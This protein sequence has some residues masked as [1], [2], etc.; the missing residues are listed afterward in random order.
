MLFFYTN[1]LEK[2]EKVIN[3]EMYKLISDNKSIVV[4][5][6]NLKAEREVEFINSD[7]KIENANLVREKDVERKDDYFSIDYFDFENHFRGSREHIKEVQKIYLPYFE[8]KKNVIDLGC[9]RCEFLELLKDNGIKGVGVDLFPPY[10]EYA[11]MQGLNV[12]CGDAI[13]FL[14]KQ[15]RVGGIFVGQ[16]VEHISIDQIVELC[17][18]A[19]DKLEK[20]GYLIMETPNPTTLAIFTESFYIDPSHNKP[21]HP[22]TLDYLVKKAGFEKVEVLFTESS[23]IPFKIPKLSCKCENIGEFNAAM[24]KVSD[25]LFGSQDY[26][27]IARK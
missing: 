27:V 17:Q 1:I 22:K 20:G 14:K 6:C 16:V 19:Y 15:Q 23:K 12:Y 4:E 9:G 5:L 21:M 8:K 10:V 3:D 18:V 7:R 26:A 13:E 24:G 2:H 11:K 25:L